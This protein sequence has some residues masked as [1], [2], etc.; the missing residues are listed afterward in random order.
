MESLDCFI[1]G[2]SKPKSFRERSGSF[3]ENPIPATHL[4]AL[5]A[6]IYIAW[7]PF[8]GTEKI[9]RTDCIFLIYLGSE[10]RE[11]A[12]TPASLAPSITLI[13]VSATAFSS[14]WI[15]TEP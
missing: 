2:I 15:T 6:D 5:N 7:S 4:F 13:I 11:I 3:I 8:S 12:E 14:A 1:H 10:A 9:L